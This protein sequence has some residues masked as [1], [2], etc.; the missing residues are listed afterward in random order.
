MSE[1]MKES[2]FFNLFL[3]S[4]LLL[5]LLLYQCLVEGWWFS[6]GTLFSSTGKTDSHTTVEIHIYCWKWSE[7]NSTCYSQKYF[8]LRYISY[9]TTCIFLKNLLKSF[10]IWFLLYHKIYTKILGSVILIDN[11]MFISMYLP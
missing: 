2:N 9:K 7:S 6:V 5:L 3:S 4:L 8:P 11:L 1:N 10:L